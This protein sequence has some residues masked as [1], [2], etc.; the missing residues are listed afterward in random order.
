MEILKLFMKMLVP[1]MASLFSMFML[2]SCNNGWSVGDFEPSP[3]D[4]MYAFVEILD[5]DSTSHFYADNVRL[6]SDN[7]CFIH[8]QWESV[9][10]HE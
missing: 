8:N 4:T 6:N 10:E 2:S 9:K 5:Q 3:R 1:V 7:W